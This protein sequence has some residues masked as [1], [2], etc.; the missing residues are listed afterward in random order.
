MTVDQGL[1]LVGIVI[2][3]LLGVFI[4]QKVSQRRLQQRQS[5]RG[6]IAVQAGRDAKLEK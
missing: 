1:A 3:V 6:G 2:A 4:K 5:V